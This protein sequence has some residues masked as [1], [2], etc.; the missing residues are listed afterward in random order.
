MLLSIAFDIVFDSN[1]VF[2]F[3]VIQIS[4]AYPVPLYVLHVRVGFT[5]TC[6]WYL[7]LSGF[8]FA[9]AFCDSVHFDVLRFDFTSYVLGRLGVTFDVFGWATGRGRVEAWE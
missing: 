8:T 1:V 6:T 3:V 5:C 7:C 4:F 9:F 2:D